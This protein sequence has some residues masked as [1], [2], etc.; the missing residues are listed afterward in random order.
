MWSPS[1]LFVVPSFTELLQLLDY[2][3]HRTLIIY[4]DGIMLLTVGN[5]MCCLHPYVRIARGDSMVVYLVT[6]N[7]RLST[8]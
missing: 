8:E 1:T 4:A 5:H 6:F 2:L 7:H 3:V